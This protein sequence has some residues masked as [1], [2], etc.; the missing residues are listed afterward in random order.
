MR[1]LMRR[2][3]A[4]RKEQGLEITD[5]VVLSW[6][7]DHADVAE[8]FSAWGAAVATDVQA[9]HLRREPGLDAPVIDL[10]GRPVRV[11]LASA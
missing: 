1:D 10:A 2:L 7:S 5:R 3:M 6:D 8:L 9:D 11:R 4:L